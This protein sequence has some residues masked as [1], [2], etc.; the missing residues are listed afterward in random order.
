MPRFLGEGSGV[1]L[2]RPAGGPAEHHISHPSTEALSIRWLQPRISSHS[3]FQCLG[4]GRVGLAELQGSCLYLEGGQVVEVQP[5]SRRELQGEVW[6]AF[7]SSPC[8]FLL[9]LAKLLDVPHQPICKA[10]G[11]GSVSVGNHPC[12]LATSLRE[13]AEHKTNAL[14]QALCESHLVF[15]EAK[16]ILLPTI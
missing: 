8:P 7:G 13:Q 4:K 9:L 10:E 1:C 12:S 14:S 16:S 5:D 2:M 11:E 15:T 6:L 3:R